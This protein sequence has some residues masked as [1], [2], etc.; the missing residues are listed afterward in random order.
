MGISNARALR[1]SRIIVGAM[2]IVWLV[3]A[4]N[5]RMALQS[6]NDLMLL[7]PV[8]AALT[9][10]WM[11]AMG[12]EGDVEKGKGTS[13]ISLEFVRRSRLIVGCLLALSWA[14]RAWANGI[15]LNEMHVQ[16]GWQ[17]AA[18]VAVTGIT[19]RII[20]YSLAQWDMH[21]RSVKRITVIN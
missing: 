3:I 16:A 4:G 15:S 6:G 8:V 14:N 20:S 9:V 10:L 5:A 17:A 21:R 1:W 2:L 11:I 18:L 12:Y 19:L 7:L 13:A